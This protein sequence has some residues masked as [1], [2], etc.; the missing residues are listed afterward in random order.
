M[1]SLSIPVLAIISA[2]LGGVVAWLVLRTR[3]AVLREQVSTLEQ[4]STA[5]REEL[6]AAN[7]NNSDLKAEVAGLNSTLQE[8]RKTGAEKLQ[9]L[10]SASEELR[11]AFQALAAD[12]LKSNNESFL[13]LAKTRLEKYQA[14]AK[15]DLEARQKA[16]E[17]LVTPI[18]ES[19]TKVDAQIQQIE[20]ERSH[21]YGTLTEQVRSLISTQEQLR[22]E[23][24]NLVKALRTPTVRGRWGE[25][26]LKRVVEM[27]GMLSYCDFE[28]QVSVN[29]IDGRLRPDLVVRLPGGKSIVVDAK[30]P[31]QAYL[32][33]V[34]TTDDEVRKAKLLEHA[35]QVRGHMA[36]L[37]SKS[38]FDQ[39]QPAPEFVFMFL[40][41]ESFFSAAL[42]QDPGLIEHGVNQGV[43][44]ASPTTLIAL[45]KAVA[46]G[47]N[48]E[49]IAENA[50][51]ISELGKDL[52]ERLCIFAGHLVAVGRGLDRAVESY[53]KAVGSL[54]SRVLV[55]AR[56][57]PELGA[58]SATEMPEPVQIETATRTLAM[59]CAEEEVH[60]AEEHPKKDSIR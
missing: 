8:E 60:A 55:S 47:W 1:D 53:N 7:S 16:V 11:T 43:I 30:T 5:A 34:E 59:L 36:K 13:Q 18:K 32:D 58:A 31:L 46:Y 44:P 50:Q 49:K 33:A 42:E 48:Q 40:P 12:A 56:R 21:A 22:S 39:F 10:S 15:G 4:T 19:L 57:F 28:E 52:Y 26:Q 14:E 51:Q 54:E 6:R 41:G 9:L 38:Y 29:T 25:I 24:G 23:T 35:Q 37:G 27:A 45:L 20:K 2:V 17:N 3:S